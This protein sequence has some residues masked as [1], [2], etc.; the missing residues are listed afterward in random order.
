M[1][2]LRKAAQ[3]RECQVRLPCCNGNPETTVLA[4][5]RLSGISG[6]GMKSPDAI[7]AW[8]CSDCHD[9][10]DRRRYTEYERDFVKL[11][12]AEGVFRTQAIL[13]RE[14]LIHG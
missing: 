13:I 12:H 6:L 2:K 4:H 7:G 10:I 3:G 14:G 8:A 5:Y 11:A 1:T 9:A